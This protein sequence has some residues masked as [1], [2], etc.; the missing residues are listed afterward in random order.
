MSMELTPDSH[1]VHDV[2]EYE[3]HPGGGFAH[4]I[5]NNYISLGILAHSRH[6]VRA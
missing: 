1:P 4:P 5:T 2:L 6:A 3:G